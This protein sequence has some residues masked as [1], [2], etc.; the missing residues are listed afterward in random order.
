M[1]DDDVDIFYYFYF[2][3]D[4]YYSFWDFFQFR[5]ANSASPL[6]SYLLRFMLRQIMSFIVGKSVRTTLAPIHAKYIPNKPTP[7]PNY[8]ICFPFREKIFYYCNICKHFT[9]IMD[10][11]Y[12]ICLLLY[13]MCVHRYQVK[14]YLFTLYELNFIMWKVSNRRSLTALGRL[15][16]ISLAYLYTD[17]YYK[18]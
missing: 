3:G 10:Y 8:K 18:V 7:L 5:I 15:L 17:Y 12:Y 16:I 1:S 9:N 14:G 6:I 13:Q 11:E 2:Y 4:G